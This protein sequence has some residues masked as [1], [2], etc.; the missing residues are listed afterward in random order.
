MDALKLLRDDHRRVEGLFKK[1]EAAGPTAHKTKRKLVDEII[2][3]L[4][5]HA[6]IEEEV[7]YPAVR[8]AFAKRDEDTV[9][10]ALEE[11]HAAKTML[12]ELEGMDP[13]HER[14]TA[15]TT[16]LI[17]NVRHHKREEEQDMF[18]KVRKV[19]K[20]A[21]LR[22]LGE[23]LEAAKASAPTRPHPFAPDEPPAN[24][25][26]NP[27]AAVMDAGRQAVRQARERVR[28]R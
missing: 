12:R 17:E 13:A 6:A 7:F 18:T 15:K 28:R 5:V 16:V 2:R 22:D 9:L 27:A 19:M 24:L 1:F 10:E 25:V 4:S 11:H 14:F 8:E 23:Q 21:E 20:P 3:E 26:A